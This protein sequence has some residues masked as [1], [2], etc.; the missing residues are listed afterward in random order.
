M[1]KN[2]KYFF[3]TYVCLISFQNGQSL[4]EFALVLPVLLLILLGALDLGRVS[5]TYVGI[6]NASR[7][8]ARYG[9]SYPTDTPGIQLRTRQEAA[10]AGVTITNAN[11]VIQCFPYVGGS[12]YASCSDA[13]KGDRIQVSVNFNFDFFS[14]YLLR[15]PNFPLSTSTT[16]A[17]I[18]GK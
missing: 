17:L 14:L 9:A 4:I 8:G 2:G 11:I 16:M 7:E 18:N 13:Y 15:M 3:K 12:P 1:P 6:T 5:N 10:G